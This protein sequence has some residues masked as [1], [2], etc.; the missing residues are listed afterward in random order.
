VVILPEAQYDE[1]L[2]A[3]PEQSMGFLQ[4]Y[5]ADRLRAVVAIDESAAPEPGR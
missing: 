3:A 2:R 5:P 4:P 1:W